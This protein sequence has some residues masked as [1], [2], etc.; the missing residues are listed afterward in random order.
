MPFRFND[1]AK[2]RAGVSE[3]REARSRR[4]ASTPRRALDRDAV[5]SLRE[6]WEKTGL[7]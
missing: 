1:L 6:E 5:Y 3:A 4:P 7:R 2:L